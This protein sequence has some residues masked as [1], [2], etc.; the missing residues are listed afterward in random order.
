M[1]YFELTKARLTALVVATAVVSFLVASS[2]APL[3]LARLFWTALGTALAAGGANAVNQWIEVERD[4]RMLRT[5]GRPLPTDRI[6]RRHALL[7]GTTAA[8]AGPLLLALEVNLPSAVLALAAAAIYVFAYTPLK[9]RSPLCT[10]VGAVSGALPPLVGWTAATGRLET[11]GVLLGAVL[12]AW[13]IPHFLALAW[14][15]REDYARGGF[16]MLPA[17]DPEGR[18]TFHMV[19]LYTLALLPCAFA[20]ALVGAAGPLYAAGSLLLG[21]GLLVL[22]VRLRR[23]RT[24]LEARRL[25]FA[26]LVYLP[27]LFGLL[28]FDRGPAGA[29]SHPVFAEEAPKIPGLPIDGR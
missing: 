23:R 7:F 21:I 17:L 26:S 14:L 25:F 24:D 28:A 1:I 16:R 15:Y 10:L 27:L 29:P 20:V 13:Q 22:A 8:A 3:P 19:I 2:D 5:R 4:R 18:V 9:T 11:G 6:G 12:F